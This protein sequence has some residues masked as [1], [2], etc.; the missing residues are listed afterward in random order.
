MRHL[1][2]YVLILAAAGCGGGPDADALKKGVSERLAEALPAGTVALGAL[3]RR[4][5]QSDIKA[6]SGETRRIIYFDAELKLER[7]FDFG[8]WDAPGVAGLVS[9]LGA[10]PKGITGITSGGNKA[11]DIV[12]A[13][14]TALYRRD[15]DSWASVASGGY[16]P[17][18]AP[19][20]ATNAP[21]SGAAATLEAMRKVID[22]V[23]RDAAP[24]QI[25]VIEEELAAAHA[26]IRARLARAA[27]GYAIA[28]GAEHG[29]YFR[30]AQALSDIKGARTISLITHG[31]EENLR[32]LR[33]GK[34]S[35]A[36]AQGDAT[37]EAYEGKGNFA[38]DGPHAALRA[39]GSLYPEPVHVLVRADSPLASMSDLKSR[40]IAIGQQ[41][42]ASRTTA[43]RVLEAHG[44]S[45]KDIKPLELSIS[46]ALI[47]LRQKEVDAVIQVIGVPAD[48]IRDALDEV[49]L[50]LLPLS[51][52]AV[53]T[54]VAAKAGYFAYAIPRGA[55][56][57]QKQDVR[58]VGTAALLLVGSDLSETEVGT[59][60][61][62][63][64][65]KGR[66]LAARGSAQGAQVSAANA[67]QGLSIPLHVAAAKS[68][69]AIAPPR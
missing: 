59:L 47:G 63:V 11:G 68:L 17:S 4:G 60:T 25:A 9:A 48:S 42:S 28:A 27:D 40:R 2:A 44:L 50:R 33:A 30:F 16:R 20:Y 53:A 7:D 54:L 10:G 3:E 5:S 21:Q 14:G 32:L 31:G 43:L 55:Y 13:H 58:T 56:A 36:L 51:E 39:V 52:R 46:D 61:R 67:R 62:F 22:S 41:G 15:G 34:V 38:G 45:T 6:P 1:V 24:A 26:T 64:F 69:D 35:L 65:E 57:T 23:R 66:D 12:R 49:P 18:A 29:Q 19:A 37:L 8:A